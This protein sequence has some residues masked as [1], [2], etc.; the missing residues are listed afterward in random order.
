VVED[1]HDKDQPAIKEMEQRIADNSS[2]VFATTDD[3]VAAYIAG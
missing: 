3:F 2:Q 1:R